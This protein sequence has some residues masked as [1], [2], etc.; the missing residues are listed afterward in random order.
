M[1]IP[2]LIGAALA[3]DLIR[4]GAPFADRRAVRER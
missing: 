2:A 1:A 3:A 4:S